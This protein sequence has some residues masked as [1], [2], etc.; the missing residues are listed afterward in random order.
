MWQKKGLIY[1]FDDLG[2]GYA[3]DPFID[4]INDKV[5]RVYFSART[6]DVISLPYYIDVEANNPS[7]VIGEPVGPLF[8]PGEP[9]TFDDTGIT[10]T[11]IVKVGNEKYIYYCGWNKK[12]TVSYSLS[13]GVAVIRENGKIEKMFEG[14]VLERSKHDPIAVSAPCVIFDEGIFKLWY[15][16]FTS[17]KEY[18]GR[19]EPTFVIKYATSVDG[20]NWDTNTDICINSEFEG[21]SFARPWV[22][23][24][25][26]KYMMWFSA[27]GPN[28]YR[29][30][31]GEPYYIDYAESVDGIN[32]VRKSD[33]FE[34]N[35]TCELWDN[36]MTAYATVV[37]GEK[38]YF[39]LYNGND[40]GKTGF[41]LCTS[42]NI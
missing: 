41:G 2:T 17:W 30:K 22:V 15:I 26:G 28:G 16:T 8:L 3:Q 34:M 27:R 33:S 39:L 5:W 18:A 10:M 37:K 35:G 38:E 12:V 14:P 19:R 23:K 11:S 31:D 21:E 40:F 9:G 6:P 29:H 24:E 36:E 20:I 25:N 42:P 1:K 7:N 32:W 4:K 13:I